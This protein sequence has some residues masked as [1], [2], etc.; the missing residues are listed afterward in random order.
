MTRKYAL[1][2]RLEI[3]TLFYID[4]VLVYALNTLSSQLTRSL[5]G[6]FIKVY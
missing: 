2:Y 1:K 3:Y 4:L 5:Q 6:I